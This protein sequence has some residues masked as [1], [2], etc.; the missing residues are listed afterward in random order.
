MDCCS[1]ASG[2][3]S[4]SMLVL[5]GG[6]LGQGLILSEGKALSS[7]GGGDVFGQEP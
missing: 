3:F 5:I 1:H 4:D 7:Q 2:P 6:V